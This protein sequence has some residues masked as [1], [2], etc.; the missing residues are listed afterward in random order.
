MSPTARTLA[1]GA[2]GALAFA[3][4]ARAEDANASI[5]VET[6][7]V[8]ARR[9][10]EDLQRIPVAETVVTAEQ[11]ETLAINTPLD[12]NKIAGLGG[13]P[14]GSQTSV[15]FTIRGQGTAFG[16]QPGVI[17]YFAEA[18]GFPL[19]Y[20][21]LDNV[22]VI[23]GPQGTLFGESSTGG[24]VLFEPKRPG[25]QFGGYVDLQVGNRGYKQLE[26]A[27][28][29]PLIK[30]TLLARVAFQLRD[31]DGWA[32]GVANSG[33]TTDLNN[34]NNASLRTSLT[35]RPTDRFETY[36]VYAH[37][38]LANHGTVSPLYYI[39]PRFMNPAV[40]NL[41]PASAPSIAAG[42]QF[43]T[44]LAPPPGQTFAQLLT[45]AFNRQ[46]AAGPLTMFTDYAQRNVTENHGWIDQTTWQV[47]DHLRIKNIASLRY[48]TIRGATYDQDATNL[49]LLD[50]QCRYA[51]GATSAASPCA[52][53]G[54]WPS[55]TI[56]E[57]LQFQGKALGDRL[58]W[59]A[60]GFYMQSGIRDFQEDTKPFIVFG[61]LSGDPAS[62]AFCASVNAPQPCASLSRTRSHTY[63]LYGQATYAVIPT[64][65]VTAGYRETWDYTRTDTTGKASY[66]V[67][68]KGQL[69]AMPVA[70]GVPAP[71]ATIV[72]TIVDLPSNGSY[73]LSVD[74]Q[75]TENVLLYAAH[76]SGYKPGG[77]NATANP[78][79][80]ERTFGPERAKDLEVG[81]KM[82]G[83][84]RGV[85]GLLNLDVF[86]TWY[87]D[88]Q[89]GEIIPGTA[90]TVTTNLAKASISG[91][92]AEGVVY[93]RPWF[94]LS[95]NVAYTDANYDKW[96]EDSTCGAQYWRPQCV[97]LPTTTA[98]RIDHAGGRLTV[99]G[100]TITFA[101]DRF[102]NASKWQWAIQPAILL[103]PLLGEDI[104]LSADIYHRGPYVDATAVA[105]TSKI[106]G[107]PMAAETTVFGNTTTNPYDA[108]GYTVTDLRF[109]WRHVRGS[110]VSVGAGVT[111]LTNK[112]Y[113]VSSASAFEI[114]GDVY[115]LVGEP[116]MWFVTLR[117]EH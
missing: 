59:Q 76:R 98:V 70:D 99:A 6:I 38:R 42:Y 79:T 77:I 17:P 68:F 33:Q 78:G 11:L 58:A 109:D 89:E 36:L 45:S 84:F 90:Q 15:N 107:V 63:A 92:E 31:R 87:D 47:A 91:V 19:T 71:G 41:A 74:W 24:V 112:I 3:F 57:E 102:A 114:I 53:V 34:L 39:D 110:N 44:G 46:L 95:G 111:N 106:A 32:T 23:K 54:G 93:P 69:I 16:G 21:D 14:I 73:D 56:T 51:A 72:S 65:H 94:R 55:R 86:H 18:P 5:Q 37:D 40:R 48:S 97:G 9:R 104:T 27:L 61:N 35:W 60:G 4:P 108:P 49:P 81:A 101:P 66:R 10:T 52:K 1:F 116:R 50:F 96:L 22:Q 85:R 75:A 8:T 117:Y 12:L 115:S 113:R 105:N 64:V 28:N 2:L 26:G 25:D 30:D 29:L 100:Q 82:Q 80:P 20:F 7:T 13:A 67:P 43:W 83:E 62:A 103:K 88:I